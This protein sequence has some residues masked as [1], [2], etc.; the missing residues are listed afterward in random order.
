LGFENLHVFQK[1]KLQKTPTPSYAENQWLDAHRVEFG[2]A[3]RQLVS[4][5]E[6]EGGAHALQKKKRTP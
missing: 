6:K 2:Y 4:Q 5:A 3:I 1:P